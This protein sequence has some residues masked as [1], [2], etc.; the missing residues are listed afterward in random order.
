MSRYY[1]KVVDGVIVDG[2][3]EISESQKESPNVEW[4]RE[5]MNRHGFFEVDVTMDALTE[6][7]D[8]VNPIITPTAV[9]F[10]RIPRTNSE[11]LK[12]VK[13]GLISFARNKAENRIIRKHPQSKINRAFF[14][15]L[16]TE[17][18]VAMHD[19][20]EAIYTALDTYEEAVRVATTRIDAQA[21]VLNLP[22]IGQED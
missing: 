8:L 2:P 1:V 14:G 5:Q 17:K 19:D 13:K 12:E 6:T 20:M 21:V 22:E 7:I 16:T 9:T 4:T 10:N 15:L 3:K 18:S 11:I